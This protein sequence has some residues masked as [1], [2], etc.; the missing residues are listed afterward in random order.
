M[1]YPVTSQITSGGG[2]SPCGERG[3]KLAFI[4]L[5]RKCHASLPV[6][7][8]WIEIALVKRKELSP[9]SL[10]VRGAWIEMRKQVARELGLS[11][12]PVRG[13]WIEIELRRTNGGRWKPSLP[14]RGAWIEIPTTA[15]SLRPPE[16]L[17]V[18]GAWIEIQQYRTIFVGGMSL[19]VRGA[20]IEMGTCGSSSPMV[21]V[22]PRAGS[23][24]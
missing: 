19:P 7:G 3:L 17:P 8:A 16:S 12:L 13:A 21:L 10:P 20:W 1:K 9:W 15:S 24:D 6:R 2:R 22:A 4:C 5:P 14:V 11:S 18:R 23:V